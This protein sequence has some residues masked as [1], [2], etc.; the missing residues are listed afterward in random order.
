MMRGMLMAV[1]A[2]LLLAAPAAAQET[3]T[4]S[5]EAQQQ[6]IDDRAADPRPQQVD[7]H[8]IRQTG[9]GAGEGVSFHHGDVFIGTF[10]RSASPVTGRI[11]HWVFD[12]GIYVQRDGDRF[13]GRFYF[14]HETWN[15]REKK[16]APLPYDGKYIMVGSFI[17]KSGAP[18]PG[19]Y[20]GE[21]GPLRPWRWVWA[22]ETYLASFE[23]FYEGQVQYRMAE[24]RREQAEE[25]ESGLSFGQLLAL[26]LGAAAMSM[27]DIPAAEA[28]EIGGAFVTDVLSGGQ[29][30][31]LEQIVT[32]PSPAGT[33]SPNGG[34][35]GASGGTASATYRNDQVTITCP[36]G[37]SSTIP[38]S[39][40]TEQCRSAMVNFA[41]VYSCN[42]ID[43]F[44][45]AA[46]QCQ[47]ACGH[48]QCQE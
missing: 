37:V 29:T 24:L 18:R 36:S 8:K 16:G 17:P 4:L 47:S 6:L 45:S 13:T 41:K 35:A 31:Q 14:F 3:I 23:R 22:D 19:I 39:Y 42:L 43:D 26:G 38:I 15:E 20:A 2:A 10:R 46:A 30:N 7:G 32:N 34:G 12:N 1:A 48:P 21:I 27:A 44:N 28:A 25:A 5:P 33:P 11:V 9:D 40:K